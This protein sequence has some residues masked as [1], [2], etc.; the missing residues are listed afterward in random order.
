LTEHASGSIAAGNPHTADAARAV[1]DAGGNA[2]DA[3]AAAALAAFVAEPLLAS[4]GGGGMMTVAVRGH[5]PSVVDFFP[6]APGLGGSSRGTPA[7]FVAVTVDFGGAKQIF[8]VGRGSATAPA[9]LD[10]IARAVESFGRL[11]LAD[12]ARPAI[13]LAR[14]GVALTPE[15]ALV[16]SLLWPILS[17]DPDAVALFGTRG[18]PARAGDV[19]VNAALAEL[20]ETFAARGGTPE[21]FA[22]AV[23][24]DFGAQAGGL[25]TP[26]DLSTD[27]CPSV[28]PP[29]RIA[30]GALE[31]LTS[32]RAGGAL[33]AHILGALDDADGATDDVALAVRFAEAGRSADRVRAAVAGP[34]STTHASVIDADGGAAAVTLTN[35]EGCGH[36]VSGTGVQLNNFL[37]EEDLSPHGFHAHAPGEILPT[38][39]APTLLLRDGAPVLAAGT[40]GANRIRSAVSQV[41]F[42]IV[43]LGEAVESAVLA[44]R[45]HAEE[46]DVWVELEGRPH[47]DAVVAA[48]EA[49]FERVHRFDR[50]NF[51]FGGTHTV[52]RR[53][54]GSLHG[55]GDPRR[56]GAVR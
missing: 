31:A 49:R 12:V 29:R 11:T 34:G 21:S 23:L 8:H 32:P 6:R 51:F 5:A 20:L 19:H 25:I 37:G 24:A 17:R 39:I 46:R 10:G 54:D 9:G 3:A 40:G 18:G 56:G 55:F 15:S 14:G 48:L 7:D 52:V 45:V 26:E 2:V 13:A 43:V 16:V 50:R 44:P 1:L 33:V 27:A 53:D 42:R 36:L 38:M 4:P 30:L 41:L 28:E 35:G 47:P 22:S